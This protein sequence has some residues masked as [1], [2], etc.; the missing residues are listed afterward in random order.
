MDSQN[1]LGRNHLTPYGFWTD[2]TEE[3]FFC[4]KWTPYPPN[5]GQNDNFIYLA[6]KVKIWRKGQILA[7][8]S[9]YFK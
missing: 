9:N 4:E 8:W 1:T 5:V 7:F 6:L 2:F 3:I